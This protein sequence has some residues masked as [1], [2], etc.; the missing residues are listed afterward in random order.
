MPFGFPCLPLPQ[1]FLPRVP[2]HLRLSRAKRGLFCGKTGRMG[3]RYFPPAFA[4]E[5]PAGSFFLKKEKTKKTQKYP[6]QTNK[7]KKPHTTFK[8]STPALPCSGDKCCSAITQD[9]GVRPSPPAPS[10]GPGLRAQGGCGPRLDEPWVLLVTSRPQSKASGCSGLVLAERTPS[11]FLLP[12]AP[13]F[14]WLLWGQKSLL[15]CGE[16]AAVEI[17]HP[18][19]PTGDHTWVNGFP[20]FPGLPPRC[21]AGAEGGTVQTPS[22]VPPSEGGGGGGS[23]PPAE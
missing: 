14:Y 19:P 17:P 6:K 16:G 11:S 12:S 15:W 23:I 13:I 7:Q 21:G 5:S 1:V 3:R 22:P 9:A 4:P 2:T 18:R 10:P 8:N 20:P